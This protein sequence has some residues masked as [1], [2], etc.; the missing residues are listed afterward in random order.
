MDK[1]EKEL[2]EQ[3]AGALLALDPVPVAQVNPEASEPG[4]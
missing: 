4:R 1:G 2:V 3:M